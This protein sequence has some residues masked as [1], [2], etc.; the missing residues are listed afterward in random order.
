MITVE[1]ISAE[2]T[3]AERTLIVLLDN[4]HLIQK[5]LDEQMLKAQSA[6]ANAK[7]ASDFTK[8]ELLKLNLICTASERLS[9]QQKWFTNSLIRASDDL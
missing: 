5:L 8:S 9:T 6:F 2:R 1:N 7:S 3:N 4:V